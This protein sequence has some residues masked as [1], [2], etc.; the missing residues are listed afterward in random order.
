M[1]LSDWPKVVYLDSWGKHQVR[2]IWADEP[3]AGL[4]MM[5][6]NIPVETIN[7][8]DTTHGGTSR[9]GGVGF[10]GYQERRLTDQLSDRTGAEPVYSA[11]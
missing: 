1:R 6:C 7:A 4:A 11:Q 3:A 10:H 8:W 5:V 2:L 9:W